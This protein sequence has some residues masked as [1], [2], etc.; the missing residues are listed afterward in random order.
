MA[1]GGWRAAA[2]CTGTAGRGAG[3]SHET[4]RTI[5]TG[6]VLRFNINRREICDTANS[7][8]HFN[9]D[10]A[11][12]FQVKQRNPY[13]IS[14]ALGMNRCLPACGQPCKSQNQLKVKF[15]FGF[16][17]LVAGL[18]SLTPAVASI[19]QSGD[20]RAYGLRAGDPA[21]ITSPSPPSHT[22]GQDSGGEPPPHCATHFR[23]HGGAPAL[24]ERPSQGLPI[25]SRARRARRKSASPCA[26]NASC[27]RSD[28]V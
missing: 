21:S 13:E 12:L 24:W 16:L 11:C 22:T 8:L 7:N 2:R 18:C 17:L 10:V 3:F 23:P 19:E 15:L 28:N 27:A 6:G 9:F 20:H 1:D 25:M 26:P 4:M 14:G 5:K